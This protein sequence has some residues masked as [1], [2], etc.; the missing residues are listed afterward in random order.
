MEKKKRVVV[1]GGG[2]AGLNLIKRL[3][4]IFFDVVL[5]D[6]NNF[7]AFPPLFYQIASSGL[8]AGSV[9]FPFREEIRHMINVH[10]SMGKLLSV[11]SEEHYITTTIGEIK[12][13]YLVI[14]TGTVTNFF[15]NDNLKNHVYTLKSTT[16]AIELRN[17]ILSRLELAATS[18]DEEL[19][20]RYLTFVVV[21][22]GATGVE[23]AGALGEMKKFIL[24]KEYPEIDTKDVIVILAEGGCRLLSSMNTEESDK[25]FLYLKELGVDVCLNKSVIF[26]DGKTAEFND[27]EKIATST[28]IWT[29][30]ITGE[31]ITGI[32]ESSFIRGRILT[33][34]YNRVAET[35]DI[36]AIGDISYTPTKEYPKGYP[37]VAQPAIQ[38]AR[39]LACNLNGT[40]EWIPFRYKDKGNMATI[41]RNKA[42]VNIKGY[43]IH[44]TIAW[45]MWMFVHLMSL[46]GMKNKII[47]FV[48]WIWNYISYSSSLRVF[49]RYPNE[50]KNGD[51]KNT[52]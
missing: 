12:Y 3:S 5:L 50:Y 14:A 36:F 25:A 4:P 22:G 15:G 9:C 19:R 11:N 34:E 1:V 51:T 39:T 42:V 43:H 30:G 17:Q 45:I 24:K 7:H 29:A 20:R 41:G 16:D 2:F 32:P 37:Q 47:V 33:D 48:N 52:N 10:Y 38:Q 23:I 26:Y 28:L 35:K 21:G 6:M 40:G 44:G 13:D 31:Y 8:D 49:I 27:K 18:V 46:L